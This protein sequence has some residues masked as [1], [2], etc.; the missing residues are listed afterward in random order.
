MENEKIK[1]KKKSIYTLY[2]YIIKYTSKK[3]EE[4][5]KNLKSDIIIQ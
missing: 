2:R 5:R 3:N 4:N 1:T